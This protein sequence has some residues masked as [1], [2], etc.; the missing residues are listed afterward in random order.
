LTIVY[1]SPFIGSGNKNI[2]MNMNISVAINNINPI[3]LS[4][5]LIYLY[6]I[7]DMINPPINDPI[8]GKNDAIPPIYSE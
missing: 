6:A 2:I 7:N 1:L 8:T 5:L 4:F 3:H